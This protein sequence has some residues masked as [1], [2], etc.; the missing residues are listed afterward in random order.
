MTMLK[1]RDALLTGLF[2]A[3]YIGLRALATGLPVWF[4]ANPREASAQDLQCAITA[5]ETMQYLIVS[6]SSQGDPLNANVPGT[7]EAPEIIHP[8][9]P[10]MA[11]TTVSLGGKT[12]G[13]ALPWAGTDV[14]GALAPATLART[15]FFHYSTRSTVHGDQPKVMKLLGA[16]T[17]SEMLVS[18]FAKHLGT[19]FG[20]VQSEPVAVGARGNASE[21]VT[22]AGRTLPSVSPTQLKQLLTGTKNSPLLSLRA[23]RDQSLA[24]LNDLAKTSSSPVQKQFLDSLATS[25]TQVRE[26]A[27]ALATTLTAITADDANGQALAAAA[28]ISANVTPVVTIHL[29]F[30]GDNHTDTDLAAEAAQTVTGVQGIQLVV[31]ALAGLGL[32][33]KV[34]F[35]TLNVFGRNLNGIAKTDGRTGRDHY[36]NHAV[37]VII[38]KNVAPGVT[39][40]VIKGTSG[41]YSASDIDSAT[42]SPMAGGDIPVAQSNVALARTLG[43][44]LGIPKPLL[45]PDFSASAG[46][47]VVNTALSG[48][49]G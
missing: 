18:M 26:L 39:G 27:D 19:C 11:A 25:R 10:T 40:G 24:K 12:Y 2:G 45:D 21:L 48:V 17:R 14:G 31:N 29:A 9:Q 4:L 28:L 13:A 23:V 44:A 42:G 22:F 7:Y 8:L 47:K 3:N 33:D 37:S 30:G 35:A 16:T 38:G 41:A 1:R 36:G 32:S 5:K 43:V 46:G 34:T 20:T 49:S 15:N 6:T